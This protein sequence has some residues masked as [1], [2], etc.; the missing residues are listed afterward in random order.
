MELDELK[1]V[2]HTYDAKLQK[3]LNLNVRF[4]EMIEAQKVKSKLKPLFWGKAVETVCHA[5]VI[6]LLLG[7]L[8]TNFSDLP[9]FASGLI[10]L[11]FYAVA[12][13]SSI[14]RMKIINRIDYSQDVVSIQKN[15][16]ALRTGN[17]NYARLTILCIPTFLAYPPVI[18]KAIKDLDLTF[19]SSFDIIAQSNGS[20]WTA[21]LASSIVLI[22]L[23]SWVYLQL[24]HRNIHKPWV[25]DFI[26]K[27]SGKRVSGA[28]EFMNELDHLK[29]DAA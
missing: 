5:A 11:A 25:K 10:L 19:F 13:G 28:L 12:I 2:W 7:Y 27:A 24:N 20:W 29:K 6:V 22:P 17:L 14:S 9:Y 15:L 8:V 21:Q 16:A 4:L 23:C 26:N 18:S 1:S 3:A